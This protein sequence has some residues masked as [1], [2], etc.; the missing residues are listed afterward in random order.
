MMYSRVQS[1]P[2]GAF[3]SV[4]AWVR[5]REFVTPDDVAAGGA[6]PAQRIIVNP[7]ARM[8]ASTTAVRSCVS[9]SA[10]SRRPA[11]IHPPPRASEI[12]SPVRLFK[13]QTIGRVQ[14][15]DR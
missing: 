7:A 10:A 2:A 5:G 6:D 15:W 13:V 3:N 1:L 4:R 11:G 12:W 8:W 14:A 9:A